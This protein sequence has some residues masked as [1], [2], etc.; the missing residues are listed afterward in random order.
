MRD[1]RSEWTASE[2]MCTYPFCVRKCQRTATSYSAGPVGRRENI[3]RSMVQAPCRKRDRHCL[4]LII[5]RRRSGSRFCIYFGGGT[6]S[7]CSSRRNLSPEILAD[8][9]QNAAFKMTTQNRGHPWSA[10]RRRPMQERLAGLPQGSASTG[11]SIGAQSFDRDQVLRKLW[12]GSIRPRGGGH[13]QTDK[14]SQKSR[15]SQISAWDL[16][17]GSSG[18]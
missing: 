8:L 6:P 10:I 2:S 11:W 15:D 9:R 12:A 7:R 5:A 3:I 13:L 17:F 1:R 16:M 14:G 4:R 18:P